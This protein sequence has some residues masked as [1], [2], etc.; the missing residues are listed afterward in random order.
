L[1]AA[2]VFSESRIEHETVEPG[3][4]QHVAA[5]ERTDCMPKLC[6]KSVS[7]MIPPRRNTLVSPAAFTG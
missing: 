1:V 2:G 4:H 7:Q 3:H 6:A 5:F